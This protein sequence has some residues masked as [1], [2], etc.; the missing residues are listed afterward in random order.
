MGIDYAPEL[1]ES[2]AC[3]TLKWHLVDEIGKLKDEEETGKTSAGIGTH[4]IIKKLLVGLSVIKKAMAHAR[5]I[6]ESALR[7]Y[8]FNFAQG[9]QYLTG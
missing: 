6:G 2:L 4:K 8:T 9:S 7:L 1:I 3:L 5:A